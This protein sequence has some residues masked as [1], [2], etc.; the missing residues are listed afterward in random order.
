MRTMSK[1]MI[2]KIFL[3]IVGVAVV[4][5]SIRKECTPK[6]LDVIQIQQLKELATKIQLAYPEEKLR[7]YVKYV[8]GYWKLL[9]AL[10]NYMLLW[11]KK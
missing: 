10:E 3:F 7:V 4:S 8:K 5:A 11:K 9:L 2:L 1:T 6:K